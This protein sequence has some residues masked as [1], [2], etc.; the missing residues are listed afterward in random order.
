[1]VSHESLAGHGHVQAA[2]LEA[3]GL[4]H[5]GGSDIG[6]GEKVCHWTLPL[7]LALACVLFLAL[8]VDPWPQF[9]CTCVL[10]CML[11]LGIGQWALCGTCRE[12][13]H[14]AIGHWKWHCAYVF[15]A[16]PLLVMCVGFHL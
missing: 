15:V 16:W 7:V 14:S 12:N 1:M 8:L 4:V 2:W 11:V 9:C 5:D 6:S 13:V 10:F 3:I